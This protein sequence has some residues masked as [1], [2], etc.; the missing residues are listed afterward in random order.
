MHLCSSLQEAVNFYGIRKGV[1]RK[2]F[3][4]DPTFGGS[5]ISK[6]LPPEDSV[7]NRVLQVAPRMKRAKSVS[8]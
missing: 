2:V 4:G 7:I 5:C 3:D 8:Q 6:S 1:K